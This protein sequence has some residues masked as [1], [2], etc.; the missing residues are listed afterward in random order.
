MRCGCAKGR[1][2]FRG[3][4]FSASLVLPWV[5]RRAPVVEKRGSSLHPHSHAAHTTAAH[6]LTTQQPHIIKIP[7]PHATAPGQLLTCSPAGR[8]LGRNSCASADHIMQSTG[9]SGDL[10]SLELA[11]ACHA[12]AV[13]EMRHRSLVRP[14]AEA[15]PVLQSP[16]AHAGSRPSALGLDQ[17]CWLSSLAWEHR[18]RLELDRGDRHRELPKGKTGDPATHH[19]A[20]PCKKATQTL[21]SGTSPFWLTVQLSDPEKA[22][23]NH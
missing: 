2:S 6:P 11:A 13:P 4:C 5:E 23:P 1:P 22:P 17:G 3:P 20:R 21:C 8:L 7:S 12:S 9:A 14:E 19:P 15:N 10:H 16:P 18:S